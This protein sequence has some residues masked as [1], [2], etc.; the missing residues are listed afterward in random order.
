MT[1]T[2]MNRPTARAAKSALATPTAE[3]NGGRHHHHRKQQ[4]QPRQRPRRLR[5]LQFN[6]WL[7]ASQAAATRED[8]DGVRQVARTVLETDADV[9]SL[10]E[11]KNRYGRDFVGRL[12]RE[13]L[14]EQQR[15]QQ[16]Q[17]HSSSET[18]AWQHTE[19]YGSFV[20]NS[21]K[22]GTDADVAILS[23]YPVVEQRIVYRTRENCIVRSLLELPSPSAEDT[24][25]AA[26]PS[27]PPP[28]LL[29]V[30]SMHLEYRYYSCYLPR[31]YCSNSH[32]FPGWAA[33]TESQQKLQML[34]S[35]MSWYSR[36][37]NG[38]LGPFVLAPS[39]WPASRTATTTTATDPGG[40]E[41]MTTA[42]TM[43]LRPVIT[44]PEVIQR[45]NVAS[46]RPEAVR[47]LI[48]DADALQQQFGAATAATA[49][50]GGLPHHHQ[51][52]RP[53]PPA[54]VVMG[55]FNEP[56][57]LD[58]V[59]STSR[60]ADH[61]GLVYE[62]DSTRLMQDSGYTDSYRELYPDPATHPGHTWPA[63]AASAAAPATAGA[64]SGTACT[65]NGTHFGG[66][67]TSA[68]RRIATDWIKGADERDRI[69]FIFYKSSPGTAGSTSTASVILK[70]VG[71][72]LV[73]TPITVVRGQFVDESLL[74]K[75]RYFSSSSSPS[76]S[77]FTAAANGRKC[78]D[79]N[80]IVAAASAAAAAATNNYKNRP[81]PS[82]HRAVMTEFEVEY[83]YY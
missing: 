14:A 64:V 74:Y 1:V 75:D 37:K 10:A 60:M 58:W 12:K 66:D 40:V 59:E 6:V 31:G 42:P 19:Y 70:P 18:T 65:A 36:I 61:N 43:K 80:R 32:Q 77:L 54:V 4:Q 46:G 76:P 63:A 45:D 21:M 28:L 2:K 22:M 34:T 49:T 67:Q 7:D 71:A 81:W 78:H 52:A 30:Y 56:S 50:K 73:G 41:A 27:P 15:Q 44:D 29:A 16:Q 39:V 51:S 9:I 83:R 72:W 38:L 68:V 55:D 69:D 17:R 26:S 25:A 62:W 48:E 13:L 8:E 23:K 79:D 82:D 24:D 47:R 11:V 20:G 3:N 33:V 53:S 5:A 57:A 35:S